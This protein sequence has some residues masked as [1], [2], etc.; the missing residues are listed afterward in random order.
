MTIQALISWTTPSLLKL[1]IYI[2]L[3]M[4]DKYLRCS[5]L[6]NTF[7][8]QI[9]SLQ[10]VKSGENTHFVVMCQTFLLMNWS[11]TKVEESWIVFFR[12]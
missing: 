2:C 9:G 11:F 7:N 10:Y 4:L 5:S 3:R 12:V 1:V 8:C 6:D